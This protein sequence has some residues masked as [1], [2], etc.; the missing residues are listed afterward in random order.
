VLSRFFRLSKSCSENRL[1]CPLCMSETQSSFLILALSLLLSALCRL[2]PDWNQGSVNFSNDC[3]GRTILWN[4]VPQALG[5]QYPGCMAFSDHPSRADRDLNAIV[6]LELRGN[7]PE[8]NVR[9]II[10][11]PPLQRLRIASGFNSRPA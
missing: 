10:R 11:D 3:S 4:F 8:W 7:L 5:F 1:C 2:Q 6:F 9:T